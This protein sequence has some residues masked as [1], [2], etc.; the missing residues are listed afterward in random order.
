MIKQCH[1]SLNLLHQFMTVFVHS[2]WYSFETS[3]I[4]KPVKLKRFLLNALLWKWNKK[5]LFTMIN[6]FMLI[7]SVLTLLLTFGLKIFSIVIFIPL[8]LDRFGDNSKNSKFCHVK[9]QIHHT[10]QRYLL[11]LYLV[12]IWNENYFLFFFNTKNVSRMRKLCKP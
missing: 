6:D 3:I 11:Q 2:Y 4:T 5:I 7:S 12:H 1:H 9:L 8:F 10:F